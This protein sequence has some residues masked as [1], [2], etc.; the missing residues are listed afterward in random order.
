M[1]AHLFHERIPAPSSGLRHGEYPSPGSVVHAALRPSHRS[2]A[3]AP[4]VAELPAALVFFT[5]IAPHCRFRLSHGFREKEIVISMENSVFP[6]KT[7]R[8]MR[9]AFPPFRKNGQDDS[10]RRRQFRR[11]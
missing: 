10:S 9:S 2:G 6:R 3:A 7:T 8:M 4:L 5:G 11:R 1:A